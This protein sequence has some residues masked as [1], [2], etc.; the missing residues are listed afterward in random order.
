M[1][2]FARIITDD[3]QII[4]IC[5]YVHMLIRSFVYSCENHEAADIHMPTA[6]LVKLICF[7]HS[8]VVTNMKKQSINLLTGAKLRIIFEISKF[9]W[10]LFAILKIF[11]YPWLSS[12]ILSLEKTQRNIWLFTHLFVPLQPDFRNI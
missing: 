12:K 4:F 3:P 10:E 7:L 2:F 8:H 11:S 9:F 1:M 6:S 5:S